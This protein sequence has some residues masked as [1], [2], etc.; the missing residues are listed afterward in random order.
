MTN[1]FRVL[2]FLLAANRRLHWSKEKLKN[3]Q[4]KRIRQIVRYAYDNVSFYHRFFRENRIDLEEIKGIEDLSKLPVLKKEEFKSQNPREIVSKDYDLNN[5]KKVRTSG[6]TG[7]PFEV[8]IDNREDSWRKAIYMR[9]NISCGQKIRDRWIVMTSPNHFHDT[10]GIQR[11]LG[12][13]AQMCISLFEST[14][15]KISQIAAVNPDIIDGYSGSLVLLAKEVK[16]RGLR[17]IN[18][19]LMFGSAEAID[20]QSRKFLEQVFDAP[21]C[22]QYGAAEVDRSAWQCLEREGYHMDFDSVITEFVDENG[23]RVADGEKGEVVFTNL[24]SFAMPFIRYAIGDIGVP[25]DGECSCGITLP[26]MKGIE[27]RKDSFLSLPGNRVMSP[28]VFNFAFSGFKY[29]NDVNQYRVRQ[30]KVDLFEV[31]IEMSKMGVVEKEVEAEFQRH[32]KNFFDVGENELRFEVSFVKE[33]PMLPT[34]KLM[35]VSSDL[36]PQVVD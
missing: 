2:Y 21:F 10:T 27:G 35:S 33:M 8:Y 22:D 14:E 34:G 7:K 4:D 11:K 18:P 32:I 30:R 25:M 5:L 31:I 15:N 13:Y 1:L 17:S 12:F 6:S 28:M 20:L 16:R 3:Y 9:A 23:E 24:F 19:S 36:A 26:L 29:Y